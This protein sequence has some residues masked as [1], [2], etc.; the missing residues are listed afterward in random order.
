MFRSPKRVNCGKVVRSSF[1]SDDVID[2]FLDDDLIV[3]IVDREV[4]DLLAA[5]AMVDVQVRR[6]AEREAEVRGKREER[7]EP[8]F[9]PCLPT[10][11]I[12]HHCCRTP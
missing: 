11:H 8:H 6:T 5:D 1:G 9:P 10:T 12:M 2:S 3:L 7:R 4:N